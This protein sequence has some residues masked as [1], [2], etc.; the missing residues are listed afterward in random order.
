MTQDER[1]LLRRV[2][3]FLDWLDNDETWVDRSKYWSMWG[4]EHRSFGE[5]HAREAARK[6]SAEVKPMLGEKT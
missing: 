1:D 3:T 5:R 2:N 4:C 6:L